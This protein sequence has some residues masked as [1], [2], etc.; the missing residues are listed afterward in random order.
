M[1]KEDI[2]IEL[3]SNLVNEL[4]SICFEHQ[5]DLEHLS[6]NS[7]LLKTVLENDE[8]E[9]NSQIDLVVEQY[10]HLVKDLGDDFVNSIVE[11]IKK[12]M[13][14]GVSISVQVEDK[15]IHVRSNVSDFDLTF[16]DYIV[17]PDWMTTDS[18]NLDLVNTSDRLKGFID[19]DDKAKEAIAM[20]MFQV[21]G[22]LIYLQ[23]PSKEAE[24]KKTTNLQVQTKG[25]SKKG[26]SSNKKK[27]Y[28]YKT[29]YRI[30]DIKVNQENSNNRTYKRKVEQ[31]VARGHWRTLKDGRT[32]WIKESV[33]KSKLPIE[34]VEAN[35]SDTSKH[36]KISRVDL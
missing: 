12:E 3:G 4:L 6:F 31:W 13:S 25:N 7:F 11:D 5:L 8:N 9:T 23:L 19:N 26:K 28:I 22:V 2:I 17:N 35:E 15:T 21:L 27:T 33:R 24:I 34:F 30:D 14:S 29:T 16:N 32:I 1:K 36:Y 18:Y 10:R 20:V